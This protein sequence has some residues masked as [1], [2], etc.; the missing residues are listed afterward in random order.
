MTDF[1]DKLVRN[2]PSVLTIRSNT[3]RS[4]NRLICGDFY[5]YLLAGDNG[6]FSYPRNIKLDPTQYTH[7]EVIISS[8]S[9]NWIS[10]KSEDEFKEKSWAKYFCD[11]EDTISPCV[12]AYVPVDK[13]TQMI[14]DLKFISLDKR[15]LCSL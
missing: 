2:S 13:I 15:M 11:C 9:D 1:R 10:P 6:V 5:V 14:Q 12:G 8:I 3:T 4:F 7:F